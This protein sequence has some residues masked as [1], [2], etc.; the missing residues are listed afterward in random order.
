MTKFHKQSLSPE[1][2]DLACSIGE[3]AKKEGLDFFDTIFEVVDHETLNAAA[4]YHGFPNRYPHWRWGMHYDR[5]AK[6]YRYGLSTIY[7]L[8][9]NTN[10]S[11]AYLLD[12]N[13]LVL[14]KTVMAH[15]YG[16]VDFFKNN[17]WFS[18][19]NRKMLDQM[20]SHASSIRKIQEDIGQ[21]E[22]ERFIDYSLSLD[23]LIDIHSPFKRPVVSEAGEGQVTHPAKLQAKKYMDS[24]VNP[25][26]VLAAKQ[27]EI[28]NFRQ[29]KKHFPVRPERDVLQFLLAH[30]PLSEWQKKVL[31]IIRT[32]AY[33]FAPQAQTKIL[34]EGWAS[35]WHSKIMTSVHPLEPSEIVDFCDLHAG[36]VAESGHNLNPYRLGIELL[37]YAKKRW[38]EGKFGIKYLSYDDPKQRRDHLIPTQLGAS[39]IFEIRKWHND[40]TFIDEFLDEDFC[41]EHKM[42]V[43]QYD[44]KQKKRVIT[45]RDFGPIKQ[46]LLDSI[47]NL[48]QPIIE[49]TDGNYKNRGELLL[50]HRFAG[51]ERSME[52][53]KQTLEALY[54]LWSRGV[55]IASQ[56]AGKKVVLSFDGSEHHQDIGDAVVQEAS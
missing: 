44:P 16:H 50:C 15:V 11:Y 49:V 31:D 14:Q 38:D 51:E 48:G 39:K 33:Y 6:T 47:T 5:L 24:Y 7:E 46:Q 27:Q 21:E 55:H 52:Q 40:V 32:E 28:D 1:L 22:V 26:D 45:S 13:P 3:A 43:Y 18:K 4:A 9:I 19:T 10:P 8:V 12:S 23:N 36:V 20:A 37:R 53:A 25:K 2:R 34:N 30:A 29:Q 17:Y 35:Y 54:H 42:F 41:H 56:V